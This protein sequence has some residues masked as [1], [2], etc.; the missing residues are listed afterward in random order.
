[1]SNFIEVS[2]VSLVVLLSIHVTNSKALKKPV[3]V[4]F[5]PKAKTQECFLDYSCAS[6]RLQS[7]GY[8]M[9]RGILVVIRRVSIGTNGTI[10][11]N[12]KAHQSN[13]SITRYASH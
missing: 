4:I 11:T 13:G 7:F 9:A 8:E 5:G 6:K 1:M 3:N 10:G 12:R 2:S